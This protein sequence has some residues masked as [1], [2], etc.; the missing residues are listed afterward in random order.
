[1]IMNHI[2][3]EEYND[4]KSHSQ[5]LGMIGSYVEEFCEEDDTTLAGVVRLLAEYHSLKSKDLYME[6]ER[7]R[8]CK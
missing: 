3:E 6:I 7:V 5:M 8:N 4:L 1:M 2:S